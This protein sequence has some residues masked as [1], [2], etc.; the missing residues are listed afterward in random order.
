MVAVEVIPARLDHAD[1]GIVELGDSALQEVFGGQEVGVEDGN[2]LAISLFQSRVESTRLEAGALRASQVHDPVSAAPELRNLTLEDGARLVSRVVENL[3]LE[4][5]SRIAQAAG[6]RD[7]S[8]SDVELVI[9]RQLDGD[10]GQGRFRKRSF[11]SSLSEVV[12]GS[13][14]ALPTFASAHE[15]RDHDESMDPVERQKSQHAVVGREQG[16]AADA[17]VTR[18]CMDR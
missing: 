17:H 14:R 7:E 8:G 1:S 13:A 5:R 9:D 18:L 12:A 10:P 6:R 3:D 2:E 11:G 4:Q 16:R 15:S